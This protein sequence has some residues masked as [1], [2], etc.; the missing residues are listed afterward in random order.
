MP[1]ARAGGGAPARKGDAS[2]LMCI[3]IRSITRQEIKPHRAGIEAF[4]MIAT[5]NVNSS[6]NASFVEGPSI[7]K[8]DPL[9]KYPNPPFL[10]RTVTLSA[11]PS[12]RTTLRNVWTLPY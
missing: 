9:V 5:I 1:L 10:F 12:P 2:S 7:P 3:C 6:I 4:D 8:G 11:D